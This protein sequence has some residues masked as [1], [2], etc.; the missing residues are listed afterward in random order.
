MHEPWSSIKNKVEKKNNKH[1]DGHEIFTFI[2]NL[3][4]KNKNE[5]EKQHRN[6][7]LNWSMKKKGSKTKIEGGKLEKYRGQLGK[8]NFILFF[9]IYSHGILWDRGFSSFLNT[10]L[11]C[12]HTSL[13]KELI[14]SQ[15]VAYIQKLVKWLEFVQKQW[16]FIMLLFLK[17]C[18]IIQFMEWKKTFPFSLTS[19]N[20]IKLWMI[21]KNIKLDRIT[22]FFFFLM[23]FS[24]VVTIACYFLSF[25]IFHVPRMHIAKLWCEHRPLKKKFNRDEW[26]LYGNIGVQGKSSGN[27]N[28]TKKNEQKYEKKLH[29]KLLYFHPA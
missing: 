10:I 3:K 6:I 12:P 9:W 13:Q 23:H 11:K 19:R 27:T 18:F 28:K 29:L 24:S 2:A 21:K 5:K 22:N 8:G 4:L 15:L 14:Y 7:A 16:S 25:A 20:K 17:Q 26:K 1:R